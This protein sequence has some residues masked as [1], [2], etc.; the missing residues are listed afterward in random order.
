MPIWTLFPLRVSL[1]THAGGFLAWYNLT[2][3]TNYDFSTID[4]LPVPPK[5]SPEARFG[6]FNDSYAAGYG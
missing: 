3:G 5:G 2:Y 1:L 6:F 4:T